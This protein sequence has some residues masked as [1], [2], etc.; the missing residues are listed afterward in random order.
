MYFNYYNLAERAYAVNVCF[1]QLNLDTLI[2]FSPSFLNNIDKI[3]VQSKFTKI[4]IFKASNSS[5]AYV[6]RFFSSI[7]INNLPCLK[8]FKNNLGSSGNSL[9]SLNY[10]LS[11]DSQNAFF[12]ILMFN[13][14]L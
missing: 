7:F 6:N 3:V 4:S 8:L 10:V 5:F 13:L 12:Y 9:V 1:K 11:L 2:K 14:F